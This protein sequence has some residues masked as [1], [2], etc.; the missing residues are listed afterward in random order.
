MKTLMD[1]IILER[2]RRIALCPL[3]RSPIIMRSMYQY[4]AKNIVHD[5]MS[6]NSTI[7]RFTCMYLCL[8]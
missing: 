1:F 8:M 5:H 3:S 2:D 6:P 4:N 7:C